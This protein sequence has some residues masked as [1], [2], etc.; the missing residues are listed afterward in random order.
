MRISFIPLALA[1]DVT[2]VEKVLMLI[3][4]LRTQVKQEAKIETETYRRFERFCNEEIAEKQESIENGTNARD[5]IKG[6]LEK[7]HSRHAG[8]EQRALDAQAELANIAAQLHEEMNRRA[9]EH[10][11]YQQSALDLSEAIT[12]VRNAVDALGASRRKGE[13]AGGGTGNNFLQ[14]PSTLS[15]TLDLTIRKAALIADAIGLTRSSGPVLALLEHGP[16]NNRQD[17]EFHADQILTILK[18]LQKDLVDEKTKL[19]QEEAEHKSEHDHMVL[20]NGQDRDRAERQLN[21]EN[22]LAAEILEWIGRST[23]D[24]HDVEEKLHDDRNYMAKLQKNFDEK[25][26]TFNQ[27]MQMREDEI[28]ALSEATD[29]IADSVVKMTTSQTVRLVH[30]HGKRV[31]LTKKTLSFVQL[32]KKPL[33]E[34]KSEIRDQ[35]AGVLRRCSMR[36]SKPSLVTLATHVKFDPF[37]KIRGM[38]QDMI[39]RL[40][41]EAAND[42]EHENWCTKQTKLAKQQRDIR[43]QDIVELNG[44]LEEDEARRAVL[45]SP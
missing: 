45:A 33:R 3:R 23:R 13:N 2:P 34:S 31:P 10:A 15:P 19:D 42:Q 25:E 16:A 20:R 28:T 4:A 24:L 11:E 17:Y 12:A 41:D 14:T 27:R 6:Q 32:A 21:E 7:L 38:I 26:R 8:S 39:T 29:I 35:I 5:T 30:S 36:I 9:K 1:A 18:K 22:K 40:Q 37:V 44:D 43:S